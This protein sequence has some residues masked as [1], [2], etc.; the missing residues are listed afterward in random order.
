MCE[1][2]V[3]PRIYAE[4]HNFP[5]VP[6]AGTQSDEGRKEIPPKWTGINSG[7]QSIWL[8]FHMNEWKLHT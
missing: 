5:P 2:G 4:T 6:L 8:W 1:G 7:A 3:N